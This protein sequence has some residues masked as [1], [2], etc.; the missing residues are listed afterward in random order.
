MVRAPADAGQQS[1]LIVVEHVFKELN[2]KVG[3]E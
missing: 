2:A 3:H 1:E